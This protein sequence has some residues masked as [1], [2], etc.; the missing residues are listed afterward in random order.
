MLDVLGILFFPSR[1]VVLKIAYRRASS[2]VYLYPNHYQHY[3]SQYLEKRNGILVEEQSGRP[4]DRGIQDFGE[5]RESSG[6][7]Q[8]TGTDPVWAASS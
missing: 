5:I 8:E 4:P 7:R 3:T 6:I 2:F 1:G